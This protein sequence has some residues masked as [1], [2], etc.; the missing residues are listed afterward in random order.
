MW[1][2]SGHTSA[3]PTLDYM[4]VYNGHNQSDVIFVLMLCRYKRLLIFTIQL[5]KHLC[6][7]LPQ[8]VHTA[9]ACFSKLCIALTTEYQKRQKLNE[10]KVSWFNGFCGTKTTYKIN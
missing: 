4:C 10:R 5:V 2:G 9:A 6:C 1:W 3:S 7:V 8:P